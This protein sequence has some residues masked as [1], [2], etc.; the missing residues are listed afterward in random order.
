M[1]A[2]SLTTGTARWAAA[3]AATTVAA[4]ALLTLGAAPATAWTTSDN[5]IAYVKDG[6]V[7]SMLPTGPAPNPGAQR[8]TNTPGVTE[9]DP[10]FSPHA[11]DAPA[12]VAYT[13]NDGGVYVSRADGNAPELLNDVDGWQNHAAGRPTWT[14]D[15]LSLV[16]FLST[17]ARTAG[18]DAERTYNLYRATR[19]SRTAGFGTMEKLTDVAPGDWAMWP[20]SSPDGAHLSYTYK[21]K[22]SGDYVLHIMATPAPWFVPAPGA[23]PGNAV[24]GTGV[25]ALSSWNKSGT[26]I[27]YVSYC[28]TGMYTMPVQKVGDKWTA[29]KATWLNNNGACSGTY[30]STDDNK[31]TF[32]DADNVYV[33][34]LSK[35]SGKGVLLGPGAH[36]GW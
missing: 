20:R 23:L 35:R 17:T 16:F 12:E 32:A 13:A 31:L 33:M 26:R 6:D 34:D 21:A 36:P 14:P 4:A 2:T 8:L 18:A 9:R 27:A 25:A 1:P 29:G 7:W 3:G 28:A 24:T 15:G 30:S 5:R 11:Q 10:A 22:G 19:T